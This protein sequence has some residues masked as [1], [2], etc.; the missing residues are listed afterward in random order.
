MLKFKKQNKDLKCNFH[1]EEQ[2]V[3]WIIYQ[4]NLNVS[5]Q[6]VIKIIHRK[7]RLVNIFEINTKIIKIE[8]IECQ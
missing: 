7:I 2:G 6:V 8:T 3:E 1:N 4:G 5:T